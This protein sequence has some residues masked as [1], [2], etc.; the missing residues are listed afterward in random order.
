MLFL[1]RPDCVWR[2]THFRVTG[3]TLEETWPD[4]ATRSSVAITKLPLSRA[5]EEAEEDEQQKGEM[6]FFENNF[7]CIFYIIFMGTKW[8]A[9]NRAHTLITIPTGCGKQRKV[10]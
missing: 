9:L 10:L 3:P 5:S 1:V 7:L 4:H 2:G 6:L 8:S